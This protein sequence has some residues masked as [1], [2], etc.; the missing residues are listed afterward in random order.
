MVREG[1][2]YVDSVRF[3]IIP[4]IAQQLAQFTSGH[5][6]EVVVLDAS[7]LATMKTNNPKALVL[8][9][10]PYNGGNNVYL[11]LGDPT[12]PFRDDRVRQAMSMAI[13][14][15]AIHHAVY[16]DRFSD[17][18]F[19]RAGLG[20]WALHISQLDAETAPYYKY[21][22]NKAKQ[23]LQASGILNQQFKWTFGNIESVAKNPPNGAL[24]SMLTAAGLKFTSLVVDYQKDYIDSGHGMRQGY[25]NKDT[26]IYGGQQSFT[27]VDET[28]FS[29][30]HSKSTQNEQMLKDPELDAIIDKERTQLKEDDRVK[31]ALDIQR[32]MAKKVNSLNGGGPTAFQFV[33]PWVQ[34]YALAT[35][36]D[37]GVG[38]YAKLWLTR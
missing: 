9:I 37:G 7:N 16:F 11:P 13:D 36:M 35:N 31:A 27:E 19:V 18:L 8:P 28:P 1:R 30:F 38:S 23:L 6:D 17:T 4:D 34:N 26:V 15:D 29:Y 22:Q 33:Q 25:F 10:F 14:R 12:S 5:L 21:D 3:A 2:P 32:Y 20:K 24:L